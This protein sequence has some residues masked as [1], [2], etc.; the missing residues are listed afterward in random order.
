MPFQYR[1][2]KSGRSC[3]SIRLDT[4]LSEL[5]K[6]ETDTLGGYSTS[7][8]TWLSSPSMSTKVD[9]KSVQILEKMPRKV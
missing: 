2:I 3:L 6:D 7:R 8:W 1:R 9:S 5:T 4:P